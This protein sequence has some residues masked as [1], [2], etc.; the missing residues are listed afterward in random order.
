[1]KIT[2]VPFFSLL[3]NSVTYMYGLLLI[4]KVASGAK[5]SGDRSR[6]LSAINKADPNGWSISSNNRQRMLHPNMMMR[7]AASHGSSSS[8]SGGG[9]GGSSGGGQV[10]GGDSEGGD[11][12]GGPGAG[13]DGDGGNVAVVDDNAS[14]GGGGS[15]VDVGVGRDP[16]RPVKHR[17]ELRMISPLEIK[18]LLEP[19]SFLQVVR[20]SEKINKKGREREREVYSSLFFF[21]CGEERRLFGGELLEPTYQLVS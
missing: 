10:G 17:E 19:S 12:D 2:L 15:S 14:N 4:K 8:S 9:G 7:A 13:G 6:T 16:L 3:L 1:M 18:T 11:D 21:C 20:C 5:A